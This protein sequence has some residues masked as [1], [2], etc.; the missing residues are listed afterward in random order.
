L[1]LADESSARL[2]HEIGLGEWAGGRIFIGPRVSGASRRDGEGVCIL[3]ARHDGYVTRFG[4]VHARTLTLATDGGR[5]EGVDLLEPAGG[6]KPRE[7]LAYAIR[8]HLHPTV[9]AARVEREHGVM[10]VLPGGQHWLFHASGRQVEL[11]D[12]AFFAAADGSR[13]A[14]QIVVRGL[15]AEEAE[16]RWVFLRGS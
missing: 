9:K 2:A 12:G 10:L 1:E 14:Q 6:R 11:E 13:A 5:L 7:G 16:T 15:A 3:D 8:F 4:L